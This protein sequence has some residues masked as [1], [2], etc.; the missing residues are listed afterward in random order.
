MRLL[1]IIL[2][3]D[4][5]GAATTLGVVGVT[6]EAELKSVVAQAAKVAHGEDQ[7]QC[8]LTSWFHVY[9]SAYIGTVVRVDRARR[10]S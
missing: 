5:T 2:G 8:L 4:G 1:G 6:A 10:V 3:G 9:A 7:L